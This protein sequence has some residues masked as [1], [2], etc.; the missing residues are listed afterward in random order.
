[1]DT[2]RSLQLVVGILTL[3]LGAFLILGREAIVA[4]QRA[5]L[6]V[7]QPAMLWIVLGGLLV[8]VGVGQL[9]AYAL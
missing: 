8:L 5:R 9:A 6:P 2:I 3:G 1:M 4:R 7:A